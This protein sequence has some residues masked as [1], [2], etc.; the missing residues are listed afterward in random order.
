MGLRIIGA[1]LGRT[2]TLSLKLALQDLL[3]GRCY[4]MDE[5]PERAGDADVWGEAYS[6]ALPDWDEFFD[7]YV[8]AVDWPAAPFWPELSAAFPDAP[9]LLSV[10]D[11]D[12]W[13]T[14]ASRTI[15]VALATYFAPTAEDNGWTRMGRGMMERF[16]SEWFD[17]AAAKSAYLAYNDHVR[18]TAP[19]GRLVE[20]TAGD[21]WG[22]ICAALG[23]DVPGRPFPHVNKEAETR[24]LLGLDP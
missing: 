24:A 18:A 17:E 14:S 1:G 3:G 5:V 22:P 11:V 19:P 9:I 23:I 20:W 6:G 10:R 4:H 13:W 8:A 21:G 2:G 15:F 12:A 7:G 16:S